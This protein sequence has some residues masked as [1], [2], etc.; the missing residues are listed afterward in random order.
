[1]QPTV[2]GM[3]IDGIFVPASNSSLRALRVAAKRKA[4]ARQR[5]LKGASP[6]STNALQR[7]ASS[8]NGGTYLKVI[9]G[10]VPATQLQKVTLGALRAPVAN[11]N[12]AHAVYKSMRYPQGRKLK[13]LLKWLDDEW[14][15]AHVVPR[16]DSTRL[17]LPN[18]MVLHSPTTRRAEIMLQMRRHLPLKG[19]AQIPVQKRASRWVPPP[20][21]SSA[22]L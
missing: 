17:V 14:L 9:S 19:P 2:P 15:Q 18:Q 8:R 6:V 20:E 4:R 5:R 1:M 13:R 7:W 3:L 22:L 10:E 11:A 16:T 21:L 12:D